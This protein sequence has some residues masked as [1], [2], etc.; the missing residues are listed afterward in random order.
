MMFSIEKWPIILQFEVSADE[1]AA[2]AELNV[3]MGLML[4]QST[5]SL[6]KTG[7]VHAAAPSKRPEL[8]R[9]QLVQAG[10]LGV[11]F[12]TGLLL[13][14]GESEADRLETLEEI[15]ELADEYGHIGE[16]IVQPYSVGESEA[17]LQKQKNTAAALGYDLEQL[18]AF[19]SKARAMLPS[20][21]AVQVPPNLVLGS[22]P[23][24]LRDCLDAGATDLGGI[25]PLDEV[26]PSYPF[27][28]V[29]E[30]K[31]TLAGWG[32]E[33]KERLPVHDRHAGPPWVRAR[34]LPVMAKWQ[35]R[36]AGP[37]V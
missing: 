16:C 37:T 19:V 32:Y 20:D 36:H 26:N 11:P 31:G 34:V 8:R 4:E 33:L 12:T 9:A 28:D 22:R 23:E 24:I 35:A 13:G 7:G 18:P 3:S 2:L 15:A 30:L 6:M 14:I 5:A 27:P 1:M 25:S 21:V 10:E 17:S 29:A